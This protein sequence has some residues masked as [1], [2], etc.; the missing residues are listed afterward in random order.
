VLILC[1]EVTYLFFSSLKQSSEQPPRIFQPKSN[2]KLYEATN[3]ETQDEVNVSIIILIGGNSKNACIIFF[4][5][6]DFAVPNKSYFD[7]SN[8]LT[9]CVVGGTYG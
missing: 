9:L 7:V 2:H 1:V 4:V 6:D 3:K 8:P 5:K